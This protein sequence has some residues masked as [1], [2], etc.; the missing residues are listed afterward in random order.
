MDTEAY[1]IRQTRQKFR[2]ALEL[3]TIY[4]F[5]VGVFSVIAAICT[6]LYP[7]NSGNTG[8]LTT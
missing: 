2:K 4:D 7:F 1:K 3:S 5:Y 8:N 6:I